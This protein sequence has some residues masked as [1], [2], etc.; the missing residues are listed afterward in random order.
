MIV[1]DRQGNCSWP[2]AAGEAR[3]VQRVFEPGPSAHQFAPVAWLN[4]DFAHADIS[5][6]GIARSAS[7]SASAS[8]ER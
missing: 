8:R 5:R 1:M 3:T 2:F 6:C 7:T 4:K